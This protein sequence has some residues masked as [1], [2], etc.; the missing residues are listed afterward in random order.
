MVSNKVPES[1][2]ASAGHY[3]ETRKW[4]YDWKY[5]LG[6][7]RS[8]QEKVPHPAQSRRRRDATPLPDVKKNPVD[9]RVNRLIREIRVS[10]DGTLNHAGL[11]MHMR[12]MAARLLAAMCCASG[13]ALPL[14]EVCQA[15][16]CRSTPAS[17]SALHTTVF[18]ANDALLR[19]RCPLRIG[20]QDQWATI[21]Y[22]KLLRSNVKLTPPSAFSG[23]LDG[24]RFSRP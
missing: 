3:W 12:P 21:S 18:R 6:S 24:A 7:S 11:H 2:T 13:R 22:V 1:S 17:I 4:Y 14:A 19:A 9:A 15:L 16:W 5:S 10:K 8:G 20:I 23:R